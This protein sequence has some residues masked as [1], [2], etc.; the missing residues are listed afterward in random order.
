[1]GVAQKK[2]ENNPQKT[3]H[4]GGHPTLSPPGFDSYIY[5]LIALDVRIPDI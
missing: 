2:I 4:V 3:N 1:V 5:Q